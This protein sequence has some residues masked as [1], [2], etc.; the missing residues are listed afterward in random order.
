MVLG[1][2][3]QHERL[4]TLLL[5]RFLEVEEVQHILTNAEAGAEVVKAAL[6]APILM[7]EVEM[8]LKTQAVEEGAVLMET[9]PV[10]VA[11]ALSSFVL[12]KEV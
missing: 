9:P 10:L 4:V 5:N 11:P 7:V 8:E 12:H 1:N 3:P 2:I 6:V